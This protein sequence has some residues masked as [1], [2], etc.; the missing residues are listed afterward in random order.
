MHIIGFIVTSSSF[1]FLVF[2][3]LI[4]LINV[5]IPPLSPLF[6]PSISSIIIAIFRVFLLNKLIIFLSDILC[7]VMSSITEVFLMSPA[8][9]LIIS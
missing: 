8:S 5:L 1:C 6:I 4:S 9:Y 7:F 3:G 2:F